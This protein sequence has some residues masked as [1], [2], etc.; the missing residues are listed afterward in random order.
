MTDTPGQPPDAPRPRTPTRAAPARPA[1]GRAG[2]ARGRAL[3]LGAADPHASSSRRSGPPRSSAS[4]RTRAGSASWRSSSSSCSC[5]STGSTSSGL[6]G[7]LSQP[8]LEAGARRPAGHRGRAWLQ[9]L[10]G[11]LRPLPR[12]ERRGRRRPDPEP[13]GQAV[14]APQRG[15]PHTTSSTVGGRYVCGNPNSPM[16]VWADTGHPPGPLNYRQIEE[17]IAFIRAPNDQ[18]FIDR[19][20]H[21][22][23]PR[24]DPVTGEVETFT[25]WVDPNYEP[26][27]GATPYP[28]CWTD[29]F[30]AAPRR[31]RQ[32]RAD[33]VRRAGGSA[34]DRS[35]RGHRRRASRS[36]RRRDAPRPTSRSRST[37]TTRTPASRTTSRSRT[38]AGT[39]LF[40]ADVFPGVEARTTRS[41]RWPPASYTV[42]LLGPPEHDRHAD[43][44]V[45]AGG[46][47][48]QLG[49]GGIDPAQAGDVRPARRRRLGL[50][51]RQGRVL[52]RPHHPAARLHPRPRLL[53][54]GQPDGR[55]RP[56]R[57]V[58]DQPVLAGE[59]GPAV[60]GPGRRRRAVA[61]SPTELALPAPRTDG[62][63]RQVG[64]KLLYIGGSDGT[65]AQV[66]RVRRRDRRHVGNF[67]EWAE[68]PA[69]P[70]R[71]PMP[72][73]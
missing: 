26:E 38:P 73:S 60:P 20:E 4:R 8:R 67:D 49:P 47:T 55:P 19:D 54:D 33:R 21:L 56:P 57:L 35:G 71:A 30:A 32:R 39:S 70:S 23:D 64:T 40:K 18:T 51:W 29:E 63:H 66:D 34:A 6:P 2:A 46:T 17:L 27:P 62:R 28:A 11:E 1:R 61:P 65:T 10:R 31:R 41:R 16:P 9:R 7:G 68:G 5:R 69:C 37:S 53:P 72:P 13:P 52:A 15:L 48:Q 24:I 50:G 3:H 25:G 36:R 45:S 12:R 42:H 43:R 14:R 59:R 22:L 44:R 58:A